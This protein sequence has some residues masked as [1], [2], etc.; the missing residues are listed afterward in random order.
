MVITLFPP[1]LD[2]DKLGLNLY[3]TLSTCV[4]DAICFLSKECKVMCCWYDRW[5]DLYH[6]K[7]DCACHQQ[8]GAIKNTPNNTVQFPCKLCTTM[9]SKVLVILLVMLMV[10]T[11]T[12]AFNCLSCDPFFF[13]RVR[14][15]VLG[16]CN[17][18]VFILILAI[19]PELGLFL[20][21][22]V[23]DILNGVNFIKEGNP[24]WGRSVI[25]V[26]FLP[27]TVVFCSRCF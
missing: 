21:D 10:P 27:M 9:N 13:T 14:T 19:C 7:L 2:V 8:E 16:E 18:P 25:S 22:V 24:I 26:T 4:W 17:Y 15:L 1:S 3:L 12:L 6:S 20:F 11:T 23:S 5:C